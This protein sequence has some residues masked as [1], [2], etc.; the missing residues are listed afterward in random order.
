MLF[1]G[2][3]QSVLVKTVHSVLR[4]YDSGPVSERPRHSIPSYISF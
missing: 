4:T 2:P 1:V 3:G